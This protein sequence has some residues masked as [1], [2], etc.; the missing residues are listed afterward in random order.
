MSVYWIKPEVSTLRCVSMCPHTYV[1]W[2][3]CIPPTY[4]SSLTGFS[5]TGPI[6]SLGSSFKG[7][8]WDRIQDDARQKEGCRNPAPRET[9]MS[10]HRIH[11]RDPV[12]RSSSLLVFL[13]VPSY[14]CSARS[15]VPVTRSTPCLGSHRLFRTYGRK[16]TASN[17]TI[18]CDGT[19]D[20]E[21]VNVVM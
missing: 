6:P 7:V 2:M 12:Y 18:T 17:T 8:Q 4:S 1:S 19:R 5:L 3:D 13:W 10:L 11:P 9:V 21:S 20:R 15:A 16:G 14:T